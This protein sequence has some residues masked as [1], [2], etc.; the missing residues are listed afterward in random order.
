MSESNGKRY[1]LTIEGDDRI[2]LTQ[3]VSDLYELYMNIQIF[4]Y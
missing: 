3:N 4:P 1:S 2:L